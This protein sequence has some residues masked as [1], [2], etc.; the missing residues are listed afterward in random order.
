VK[1][2]GLGNLHD[3]TFFRLQTKSGPDERKLEQRR[4]GVS[5]VQSR[6]TQQPRLVAEHLERERIPGSPSTAPSLIADI[7]EGMSPL[8]SPK[9]SYPLRRLSQY[10]RIRWL[11]KS[12]PSDYDAKLIRR[13]RMIS[14][15]SDMIR[16]ISS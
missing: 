14:S 7:P 13:W 5:R 3:S 4:H 12:V 15:A 6:L 8:E 11:V 10:Y 16:S 9:A 1:V 2:H